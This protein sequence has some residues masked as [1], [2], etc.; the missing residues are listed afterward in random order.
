[1]QYQHQLRQRD[2]VRQ[3]LHF[4]LLHPLNSAPWKQISR[5]CVYEKKVSNIRDLVPLLE[6]T[7]QTGQPC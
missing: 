3:R 6:K 7:A 4:T 5:R 1:M 2:A